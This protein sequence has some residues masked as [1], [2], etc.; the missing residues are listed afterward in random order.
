[1]IALPGLP[2]LETF[3]RLPAIEKSPAWEY[4]DG[5][6][7]QKP[8][9][10]GKHSPLRGRRSPVPHPPLGYPGACSRWF[11]LGLR[12]FYVSGLRLMV[13]SVCPEGAR[14]R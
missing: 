2:T 8:M 11:G 4:T 1:M 13:A 3:L 6:V 12:C 7:I 10:G 14:F 9:P 5:E